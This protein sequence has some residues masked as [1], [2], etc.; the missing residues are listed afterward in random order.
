MA[1]DIC[2]YGND[3]IFIAEGAPFKFFTYNS[4][5][6]TNVYFTYNSILKSNIYIHGCI[7]YA[8][9]YSNTDNVH[10]Y[11]KISSDYESCT[12]WS[13]CYVGDESLGPNYN[14]NIN[15][16]LGKFTITNNWR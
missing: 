15:D 3:K 4:I 5:T 9:N 2:V 6:K 7:E 13:S 16:C 14:F 12:A 1:T 10:Y 11:W 8:S